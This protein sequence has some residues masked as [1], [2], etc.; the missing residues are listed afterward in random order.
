VG[1]RDYRARR[2]K[3]AWH[4]FAWVPL[5]ALSTGLALVATV[6]GA[7]RIGARV[8]VVVSA[9]ATGCRRRADVDHPGHAELV[10]AHAELVAPDLLLQRHRD[11]PARGQLFPVAVQEVR[12]V[13]AEADRNAGNGLIVHVTGHDRVAGVGLQAPVHDARRGET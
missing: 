4:R 9:W 13:A 1:V 6:R 10:D 3:A 12:V 7:Y 5:I 2:D 11:G 8:T